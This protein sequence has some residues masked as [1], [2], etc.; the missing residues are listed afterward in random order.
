MNDT[1]VRTIS[2]KFSLTFILSV[3]SFL[4]NTIFVTVYIRLLNDT[5]NY[6]KKRS[7]ISLPTQAY[8]ERAPPI[9]YLQDRTTAPKGRLT[10]PPW[11]GHEYNNNQRRTA[12]V[13]STTI[14]TTR[15]DTKIH[16]FGTKILARYLTRN[17]ENG[18]NQ[19]LA[20][21]LRARQHHGEQHP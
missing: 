19:Y 6:P 5:L 8:A 3:R 12:P 21:A 18:P 17:R 14:I 20:T 16:C 11:R 10:Q 2:C 15:Y 1:T 9:L 4:V 7:F 13:E